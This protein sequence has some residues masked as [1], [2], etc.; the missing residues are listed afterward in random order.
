MQLLLSFFKNLRQ[1]DCGVKM[2]V[3]NFQFNSDN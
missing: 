2:I 1:R 3:F